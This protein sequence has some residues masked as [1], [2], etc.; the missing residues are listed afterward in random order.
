LRVNT[1]VLIMRWFTGGWGSRE[2][3]ALEIEQSY[4]VLHH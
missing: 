1:S 4:Y 2:I 3:G